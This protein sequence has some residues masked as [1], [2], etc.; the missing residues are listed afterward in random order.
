MKTVFKEGIN[1]NHPDRTILTIYLGSEHFSFSFYD[2]QETGSFFY[3]ELT[4]DD[5]NDFFSIIKEEFFDNTF[6]SLPFRKVWI[7]YRTPVFTFVPVLIC[8]D[9]TQED[10][11]QYLFSEQKGKMLSH[12]ISSSGI[13]VL[14]QMPETI[15]DFM[16]R[17]FTKPEFIHYSEPL[18]AFFLEKV[19]DSACRMVVNL[20]EKGIDIFCFSK[21]K[22]LLGNY[23]PC[24]SPSEMAY[25]ILFTWKQL[26]FNQLNDSL[27][28][29]G[30]SI[31]KYELINM[32][33]Q[34]V[35]NIYNLSVFP[36]I[37][38]EG[39][40]TE[41]TPFELTTLSSCGL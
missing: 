14:F 27:H 28:F 36:E 41:G 40:E 10:F 7:M 3:K 15:Y 39:V 17:S 32:L 31:L 8:Q 35:Q 9:T 16:N 29:T 33:K 38:F 37:H 4:I 26:Q 11:M 5:Q 13:K 25:Y 20:Q 21:D 24:N 1:I 19:K 34:Y 6:F 22:F 23:F 12:S 30:N 2:P 18:I